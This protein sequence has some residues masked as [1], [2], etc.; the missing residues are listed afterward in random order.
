MRTHR[1]RGGCA[2]GPSAR[3]LPGFSDIFSVEASFGMFLFSGRYKMMPELRNFP[4]DFTLLFF[5]TTFCLIAWAVVSG[6]IRPFP[7]NLPILLMMLFSQLAAVSL[8]WSSLDSLNIDKTVR[9]L[10]LTSTSF[11][12]AYMIGQDQIR[13]ERLLRILAWLS[14]AILT[15]YAYY[16]YV[17]DIDMQSTG[18]TTSARVP[19]DSN[20][21]LEYNAHASI[22][23]IIFVALAV[24]GSWKQICAAIAGSS[25]ALFL[26]VTIGGRGPLAL[27]LLA[28][29]LLALGLLIRMRGSLGLLVRLSIFIFALT[30]IAT[31]GYVATTQQ[32][33]SDTE[34]FRT[35][36][37]Y[38]MQLSGEQTDSV[39][40]RLEGQEFAFRQW[41]EKPIVGWGFGE[42]RVKDS[43]L[44]YP[45]NLVLE[46]LMELGVVGAFLF[47]SACAAAVGACVHVAR[48]KAT[49]W[50]DTAISL[51]FL[52]ELF[53]HVTAQGYLADDRVF[54]A[55]IGMA[56]AMRP[57]VAGR[58]AR[59]QSTATRRLPLR[60]AAARS[61]GAQGGGTP[62]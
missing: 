44:N 8:F 31:I 10:L 59:A 52:T 6:R 4:V 12:A 35:L 43:Y 42:F 41:L 37:R 2:S 34:R 19:A 5:A 57:V 61:I 38:Q 55:Y 33:G 1:A 29:P 11:F 48:D 50:V 36:E 27:A 18:A 9:F 20:T 45:H 30:A 49:G 51:L 28:M 14:C 15:Y 60:E 16:R 53:S 23:F 58:G 24:F 26:L 46:I 40:T 3:F 62:I 13:R 32:A 7:L 22:L 17:L 25:I 39:D 21:Y 47:F 56:I 54:F